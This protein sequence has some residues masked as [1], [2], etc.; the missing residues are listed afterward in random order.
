[1]LKDFFNW[2][3]LN[4]FGN[5]GPKHWT[6][7]LSIFIKKRL[8]N[9]KITIASFHSK[10][11]NE[12]FI[13]FYFNN[14]MGMSQNVIFKYRDTHTGKVL[15]FGYPNM[16]LL[17]FGSFFHHFQRPLE[18]GSYHTFVLFSTFSKLFFTK[19]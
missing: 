1:M 14:L 9:P 4:A 7:K 12:F 3:S 5:G 15:C 16:L 2:L 13:I 19:N 8:K 18:N 10:V 6:L 17:L 11:F